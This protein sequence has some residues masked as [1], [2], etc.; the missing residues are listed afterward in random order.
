[1]VSRMSSLFP[2]TRHKKEWQLEWQ[3]MYLGFTASPCPRVGLFSPLD[4][5]P[6]IQ[7]D[8]CIVININSSLT[9]LSSR[10]QQLAELL[11]RYSEEVVVEA[12]QQPVLR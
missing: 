1:M 9:I 5:P 6:L 12:V 4:I 11:L 7:E 8:T 10:H 3:C 2:G